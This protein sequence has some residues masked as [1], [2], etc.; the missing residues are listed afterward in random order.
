MLWAKNV[1]SKIRQVG[2]PECFAILGI[3]LVIAI[4][5]INWSFFFRGTV[6][7]ASMV[8]YLL[9]FLMTCYGLKRQGLGFGRVFFGVAGTAAARWVYEII[10]HYS[11]PDALA[12]V[13]K[14]FAY[15]STNIVEGRFPLVWSL[16][17]AVVIFTGYRY[18]SVNKC[19]WMILLVSAVFFTFWILVGYPQ[20]VHPEWWPL[21]H[22]LFYL[23]PREYRHAPSDVAASAIS[24]V[25]LILNS[26]TKLS[27]CALLPSLFLK[28]EDK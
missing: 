4:C 27:V 8:G 22:P 26:I 6:L 20:W 12:R 14:D 23:I 1:V 18:M 24:Q 28:K 9:A 10:Y 13:P 7:G 25:S 17:M 11:W 3:V 16:M 15:M 19:F 5:A 21:R 2:V